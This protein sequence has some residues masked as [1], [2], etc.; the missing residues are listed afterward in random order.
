M[1]NFEKNQQMKKYVFSTALLISAF[2]SIAQI[3]QGRV[4]YERQVKMQGRALIQG[5]PE[6][7]EV[8]RFLSQPRI[9]RFEL[10]FG[11]NQ[12]IWQKADDE[13]PAEELPSGGPIRISFMGGNDDVTFV[14]ISSGKRTDQVEVGGKKFIVEDDIKQL[15]WKVSEETKIILGHPCRKATAETVGKR[16]RTQ[17]INGEIKKEEVTD[18]TYSTAW[19]A[20]DIPVFAGPM[21]PKQLPGL[22]L[23]LDLDNGRMIYKAI[24]LTEKADVAKIKV[25]QKGK[26]VTTQELQKERDALM[27]QMQQNFKGGNFTIRAGS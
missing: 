24:E 5:A 9:D 10:L 15:N 26:K 23:E 18:T 16:P 2:S 13:M 17:I 25:P 20:T 14:D 4:L 11:N 1:Y 8:A 27:Q 12:S 19:F 7:P 6:N 21:Y 22:I 3:K